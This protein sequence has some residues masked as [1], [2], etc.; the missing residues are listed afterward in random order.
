MLFLLAK[1]Y[2]PRPPPTRK[3][4]KTKT[5]TYKHSVFTSCIDFPTSSSLV[6]CGCVALPAPPPFWM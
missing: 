4:Q 6:D 3:K 5:K 2:R 1:S